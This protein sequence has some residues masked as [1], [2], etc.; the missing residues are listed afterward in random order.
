VKKNIL[1]VLSGA[2]L[3]IAAQAAIAFTVPQQPANCPSVA[4]IKPQGV[5]HNTIQINKLW[6]AGHRAYTYNTPDEWTFVVGNI[7]AIDA[8][9]AFNKGMFSLKTLTFQS[10]PFYEAQLNRW[11]C[12]YASAGVG[13][14][15]LAFNPP[16]ISSASN[17]QAEFKNR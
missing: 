17:L 3:T 7:P 14:P 13:Y 12:S 4:L 16:L 10:G 6:F 8:V 2:V 15:A 11:V 1:C 9:D 5:S